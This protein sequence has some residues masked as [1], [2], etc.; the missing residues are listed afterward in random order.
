VFHK[1]ISISL[2]LVFFLYLNLSRRLPKDFY[3]SPKARNPRFSP[4]D[5]TPFPSRRTNAT[6]FLDYSPRFHPQPF[7]QQGFLFFLYPPSRQ[8]LQNPVDLFTFE[9][10]AFSPSSSHYPK[11][12][13]IFDITSRHVLARAPSE[14]TLRHN[15]SWGFTPFQRKF[16]STQT[17]VR[18]SPFSSQVSMMYFCFRFPPLVFPDHFTSRRWRRLLFPL[19][20]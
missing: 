12:R 1:E 11:P 10:V 5:Q 6:S 19:P 20:E 14:F 17:P 2:D 16:C 7:L 15:P 13:R 18:P 8:S 9:L 3:R 4:P